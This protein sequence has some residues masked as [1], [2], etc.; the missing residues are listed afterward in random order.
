[1]YIYI[2]HKIEAPTHYSSRTATVVVVV[3]VVDAESARVDN[4][5]R[6]V[7]HGGR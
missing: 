5:F 3:V 2:I 7:T 1:M 4:Q 6:D